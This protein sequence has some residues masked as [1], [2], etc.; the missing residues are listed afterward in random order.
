MSEAIGPVSILPAPDQEQLVLPGSPDALSEMSRNL[1][2]A[3]TRRIIDECYTRALGKLRENRAQLDRVAHALLEHETLDEA[4]AYRVAGFERVE[5][6]TGG[7]APATVSASGI[8]S[9]QSPQRKPASSELR[10][11][12]G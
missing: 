12:A 4:D 11:L 9:N 10:A 8:E 2:E 6:A 7:Q 1:I 3:E 5:E